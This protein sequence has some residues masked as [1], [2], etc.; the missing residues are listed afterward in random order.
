MA[1]RRTRVRKSLKHRKRDIHPAHRMRRRVLAW[2]KRRLQRMQ[3]AGNKRG[4]AETRAYLK[5]CKR[6]V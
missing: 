4:V 1:R 2:V 5:F 6:N 3:A